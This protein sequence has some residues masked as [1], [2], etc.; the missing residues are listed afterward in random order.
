MDDADEALTFRRVCFRGT[1]ICA[2]AFEVFGEG[3]GAFANIAVVHRL[4]TVL[5]E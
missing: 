5:E 2:L 1:W 3:S 4:T